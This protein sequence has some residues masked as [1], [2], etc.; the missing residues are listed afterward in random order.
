MQ[1]QSVKWRRLDFVVYLRIDL[2]SPKCLGVFLFYIKTY[3][4]Y[5]NV[6]E[7]FNFPGVAEMYID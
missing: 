5:V 6:F 1:I 2:A 7:Y 4:N 3:R